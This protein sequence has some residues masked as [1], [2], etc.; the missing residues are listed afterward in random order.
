VEWIK[1]GSKV[2]ESY[3]INKLLKFG[4]VEL[5]IKNVNKNEIGVYKCSE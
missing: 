2:E 3:R 4:Y 1:D 5:K